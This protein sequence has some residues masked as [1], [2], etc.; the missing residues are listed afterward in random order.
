MEVD[1]HAVAGLEV[2]LDERVLLIT[3]PEEVRR[4][5]QARLG[6]VYFDL[7][8]DALAGGQRESAEQGD[9]TE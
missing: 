1:E 6:G 2:W 3:D 5:R 8:R 9:R 7:R 4:N